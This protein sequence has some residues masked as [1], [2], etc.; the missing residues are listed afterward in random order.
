MIIHVLCKGLHGQGTLTDTLSISLQLVSVIYVVASFIALI[1]SA[2][3]ILIEKILQQPLSAY[4][5]PMG[6][7]FIIHYV[8]A[9][10]YL[11]ISLKKIHNFD[12]QNVLALGILSLFILQIPCCCFS[13]FMFTLITGS[14]A[15][16]APGG[17][18]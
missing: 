7:Y 8:L 15:V 17:G 6:I 10:I 9:S 13:S 16:G 11:P 1:F 5:I 2:F 14:P 3:F 12:W 4:E 18:G